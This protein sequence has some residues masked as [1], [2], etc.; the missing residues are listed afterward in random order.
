MPFILLIKYISFEQ[1]R[2]NFI[3]P[4]LKIASN[5]P[6][7]KTILSYFNGAQFKIFLSNRILLHMLLFLK[8][9]GGRCLIGIEAMTVSLYSHAIC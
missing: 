6:R 1:V 9:V 8:C 2:E 4:S 3:E 7:L 5:M